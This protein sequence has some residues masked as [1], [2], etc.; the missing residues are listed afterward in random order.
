[1]RGNSTIRTFAIRFLLFGFGLVGLVKFLDS[2][3]NGKPNSFVE[4]ANAVIPKD[5]KLQTLKFARENPKIMQA[6]KPEL[7][8]ETIQNG[9]DTMINE[10]ERQSQ[11]EEGETSH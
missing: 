4:A 9:L 3:T 1:M 5:T 8:T 7:D 2:A 10:Y 6:I 11:T